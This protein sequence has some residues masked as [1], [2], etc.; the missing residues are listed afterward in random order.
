MEATLGP[1]ALLACT[2]GLGD[3]AYQP[4]HVRCKRSARS[5]VKERIETASGS[6]VLR[7]TRYL[8]IYVRW[9]PLFF[10]SVL[11]FRRYTSFISGDASQV[12]RLQFFAVGCRGTPVSLSSP[13]CKKDA[14]G[15]CPR[16][17]LSPPGRFLLGPLL[18]ARFSRCLPLNE[19]LG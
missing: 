4:L 6:S 12:F 1:F 16:P 19:V 7:N 13:A 3:G 15:S 5:P 17:W 10:T 11:P 18:L 9:F 14:E 2:S 8:L